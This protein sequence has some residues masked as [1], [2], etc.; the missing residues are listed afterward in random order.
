MLPRI[1]YEPSVVSQND[2]L[3]HEEWDIVM[4]NETWRTE[5]EEHW[6]TEDD[7]IFGCSGCSGLGWFVL[8]WARLGVGCAGLRW[9]RLDK[10]G[11]RG[12]MD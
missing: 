6:T 11:L 8:G 3:R 1:L 7:H 10:A 4:V 5:K 2:D 12:A 9:T